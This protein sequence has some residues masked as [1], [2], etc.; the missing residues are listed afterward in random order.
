MTMQARGHKVLRNIWRSKK[1]AWHWWVLAFGYA[2]P[3]RF[4]WLDRHRFRWHLT[5]FHLE[6]WDSTWEIGICWGKKTVYL[7]RH[8]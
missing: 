3:K 6:V 5:P 2:Q 4:C 1:I 8:K 7:M